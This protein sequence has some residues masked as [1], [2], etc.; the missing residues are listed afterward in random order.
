M[1][2]LLDA[3]VIIRYFVAD[4]PKKAQAFENYSKRAGRSCL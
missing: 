2:Y 3:N 4:D 1:S